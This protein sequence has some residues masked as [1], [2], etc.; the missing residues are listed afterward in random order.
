MEDLD[1]VS[2][3]EEPECP[4]FSG[5]LT[6][7]ETIDLN[8]IIP[9]VAV[10]EG[11][12]ISVKYADGS[13]APYT[14]VNTDNGSAIQYRSFSNQMTREITVQVFDGD[15]VP[16]T[17]PLTIS[18]RGYVQKL[19]PVCQNDVEKALM[20][21]ML[22]YGALAQLYTDPNTTDLANSI[23]DETLRTFINNYDLVK[24]DAYTSESATTAGV[25][26]A[27]LSLRESVVMNIQIAQDAVGENDNL[28]VKLN[29]KELTANQYQKTTD[30]DGKITISYKFHSDKMNQELYVAIVDASGAVRNETSLSIRD[31]AHKC[32]DACEATNRTLCAMLVA[33][34]DY[35]ALAQQYAGTATDDLA[36]RYVSAE[37][38]AWLTGYIWP[39]N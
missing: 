32:M 37:Q 3:P 18:V 29:G 38:R 6:L 11:N 10:G 5:F 22:D 27:N 15:G 21:R 19:L 36:N 26:S 34:L 4:S 25:F 33:M 31:Y 13:D 24:P 30:N 8:L 23:I 28:V 1:V 9:E 14:I 39:A 12:E 16:L 7:N 35:G 17:K 20:I 2:V